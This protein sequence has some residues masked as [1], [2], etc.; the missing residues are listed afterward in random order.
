M[1]TVE[2]AFTALVY[3]TGIISVITVLAVIADHLPG[4][5]DEED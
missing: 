1:T 3:W 4:G 2:A 5:K